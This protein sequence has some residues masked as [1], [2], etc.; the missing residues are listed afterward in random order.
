MSRVSFV[1]SCFATVLV[2]DLDPNNPCKI[3][4]GALASREVFFGLCL[5]KTKG[6]VSMDPFTAR[7]ST[8]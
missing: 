1:A 7:A 3:N 5:S 4:S 8:R 2:L 6:K